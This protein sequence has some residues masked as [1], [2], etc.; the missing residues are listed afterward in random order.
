MDGVVASELAYFMDDY[1]V[2][3]N[4]LLAAFR[5]IPQPGVPPE[6]YWR[7]RDLLLSP[8]GFQVFTVGG[9]H[10]VRG[11]PGVGYPEY[12]SLALWA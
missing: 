5:V 9:I 11:Y 2:H 1:K 8:R 4:D 3:A 12:A 10:Y 6:E 7:C